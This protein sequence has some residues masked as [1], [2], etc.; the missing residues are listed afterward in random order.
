MSWRSAPSGSFRDRESQRVR[1]TAADAD[2]G[3]G[4]L[5]DIPAAV[6]WQ[7]FVQP[8][9]RVRRSFEAN[10]TSVVFSPQRRGAPCGEPSPGMSPEPSVC[11]EPAFWAPTLDEAQAHV[12][13]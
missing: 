13:L 10:E 2:L 1:V 3:V 12:K 11:P 6:V 8:D 4:Y 5:V 7:H 9:K